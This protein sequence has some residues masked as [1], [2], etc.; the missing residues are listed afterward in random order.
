[1]FPHEAES[2]FS[3]DDNNLILLDNLQVLE[4]VRDAA[5]IKKY[6][7]KLKA[8]K[9]IQLKVNAEKDAK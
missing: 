4:E 9:K 1:M 8:S 2:M 6:A 5:N 7:T 3:E